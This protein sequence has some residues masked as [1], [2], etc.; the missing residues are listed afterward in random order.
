MTDYAFQLPDLA[1]VDVLLADLELTDD[2][3]RLKTGV[4]YST[5]AVE[6]VPVVLDR[7]G[8]VTTDAKP[9]EGVH[10]NLRLSGAIEI[11]NR[12]RPTQDE[13]DAG[14]EFGSVI[15]DKMLADNEVATYSRDMRPTT[16]RVKP[17]TAV[18][19]EDI[20]NPYRVYA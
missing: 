11:A 13:I 6:A 12:R 5:F 7:D 14:L 9:H 20:T 1:A 8:N 16:V 3:G 15:K 4:A 18:L 10:M 17:I 2:E 19:I